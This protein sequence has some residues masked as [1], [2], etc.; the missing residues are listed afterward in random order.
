MHGKLDV[1]CGTSSGNMGFVY[2]LYR[3]LLKIKSRVLHLQGKHLTVSHL[4]GQILGF[5][6][7][8]HDPCK[9]PG[10]FRQAD[11]SLWFSE[12]LSLLWRAFV[13]TGRSRK[14]GVCAPTAM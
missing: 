9:G 11:S 5:E 10:G 7:R 4:T 8:H 14:D 1:E 6:R 2:I 3:L 13:S 12:G